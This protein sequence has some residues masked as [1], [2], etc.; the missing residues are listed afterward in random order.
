MELPNGPP[1]PCL[2][3]RRGR[4]RRCAASPRFSI[5][6]TAL[7]VNAPTGTGAHAR[8]GSARL[9]LWIT[10]VLAAGHRQGFKGIRGDAGTGA[11]AP[12]G[13]RRRRPARRSQSGGVRGGVRGGVPVGRAGCGHELRRARV[14]R[15]LVLSERR[16]GSSGGGD[17]CPGRLPPL[18]REAWRSWEAAEQH[19]VRG[20]SNSWLAASCCRPVGA[21]P[22]AGASMAHTPVQTPVT[23][24]PLG[25]MSWRSCRSPAR[26]SRPSTKRGPGRLNICRGKGRARRTGA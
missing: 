3:H 17:L 24:S 21:G 13:S 6:C 9:G 4:R 25:M 22:S 11:Q 10:G 18:P 23:T 5:R 8:P 19:E 1:P 12:A 20:A 7:R 2:I 16:G 15:R 26:N 14:R